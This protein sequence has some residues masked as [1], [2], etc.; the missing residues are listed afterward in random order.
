M[1]YFPQGDFLVGRKDTGYPQLGV[2]FPTPPPTTAELQW[3]G[4]TSAPKSSEPSKWSL[5]W[6]GAFDTMGVNIGGQPT[7]T[8]GAPVQPR[9]EVPWGTIAIVGGG[10]GIVALLLLKKKK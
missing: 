5:F 1:S 7:P 6:K 8:P 10:I 4:T 3:S 2:S 9:S